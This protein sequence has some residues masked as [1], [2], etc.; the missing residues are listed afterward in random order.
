MLILE[1]GEK[2]HHLMML[3]LGQREIMAWRE[4]DDAR[5]P[6]GGSR[7]IDPGRRLEKRRRRGPDARMIVVEHVDAGIRVVAVVRHA[8]VAGAEV[9]RGVVRGQLAASAFDGLTVPRPV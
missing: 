3:K 5:Q 2:I 4:A 8:R 1:D 6:G 9:T 7:A